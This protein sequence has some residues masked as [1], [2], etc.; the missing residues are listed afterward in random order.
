MYMRPSPAEDKLDACK[1]SATY[2]IIIYFDQRSSN[3]EE[4]AREI[5]SF[6]N[7]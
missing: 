6:T 2:G 4:G 7:P 3:R 5:D 1:K